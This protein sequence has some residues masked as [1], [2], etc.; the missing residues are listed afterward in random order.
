MQQYI[1]YFLV[2]WAVGYLLYKWKFLSLIN[3]KNNNSSTKAGHCS[4]A[5]QSCPVS[6]A[7]AKKYH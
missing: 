1:V 6:S 2:L 3:Q 4:G 5:C 7:L